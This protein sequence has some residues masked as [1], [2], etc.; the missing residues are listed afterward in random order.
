MHDLFKGYE[1]FTG[2][3]TKY[4]GSI[5]HCYCCRQTSYC[6]WCTDLHVTCLL[7]KRICCKRH[8]T[9][10]YHNKY[11][12]GIIFSISLLSLIYW[13]SNNFFSIFAFLYFKISEKG[14]I[15]DL[16]GKFVRPYIFFDNQTLAETSN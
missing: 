5:L 13:C 12:F 8:Q 16:S 4:G 6:V 3:Q 1:H 14:S 2:C 11:L 10:A 7:S 15:L 9:T